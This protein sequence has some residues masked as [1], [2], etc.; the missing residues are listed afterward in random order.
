MNFVAVYLMML[1]VWYIVPTAQ[2]AGPKH[3]RYKEA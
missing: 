3:G 2:I 1:D